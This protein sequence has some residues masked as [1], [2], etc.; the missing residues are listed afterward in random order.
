MIWYF[1]IGGIFVLVAILVIASFRILL[2]YG[3]S[4]AMPT[5]D[6]PSSLSDLADFQ[7]L[8]A[9]ERPTTRLKFPGGHFDDEKLLVFMKNTLSPTGC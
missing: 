1:G 4:S 9:P 8:N 3:N 2:E 6:R 7:K 5:A